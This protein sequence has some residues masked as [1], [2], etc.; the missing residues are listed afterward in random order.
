MIPNHPFSPPV[1]SS[2]VYDEP[3]HIL[4][5]YLCKFYKSISGCL[6]YTYMILTLLLYPPM[7]LSNM[8]SGQWISHSNEKPKVM[9]FVS[10]WKKYMITS[11]RLQIWE[12]WFFIEYVTKLDFKSISIRLLFFGPLIDFEHLFTTLIFLVHGHE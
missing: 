9:F 10:Y 1:C 5:K 6:F 7:S 4:C 8:T 12:L 11:H 3:G 2:C